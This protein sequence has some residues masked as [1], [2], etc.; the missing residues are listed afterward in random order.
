MCCLLFHQ[1]YRGL[2]LAC[3]PKEE[4]KTE[5]FLPVSSTF[6]LRRLLLAWRVN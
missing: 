6:R 2:R 5:E 1:H 3:G 4:A